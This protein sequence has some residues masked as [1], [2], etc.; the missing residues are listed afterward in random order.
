MGLSGGTTWRSSTQQGLARATGPRVVNV[1]SMGWVGL[2][3]CFLWEL[4]V[5]WM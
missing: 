2:L 5:G 4:L 3:L 1:E